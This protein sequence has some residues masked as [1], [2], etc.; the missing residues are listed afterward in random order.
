MPED[1][2]LG[3]RLEDGVFVLAMDRRFETIPLR[4]SILEGH[5]LEIGGV[6]TPFTTWAPRE[7]SL[8]LSGEIGKTIRF[9]R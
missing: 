4:V 6:F 3:F 9:R 1:A 8:I 7:K 5:G 2:E